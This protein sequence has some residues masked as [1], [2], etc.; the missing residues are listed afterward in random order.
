MTNPFKIIGIS[1]TVSVVGI[2][3]LF[4]LPKML[5]HF[6]KSQWLISIVLM[7]LLCASILLNMLLNTQKIQQAIR[8]KSN[9]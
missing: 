7:I 5:L 2:L 6:N 3:S 4:E 9:K 1:I 8:V